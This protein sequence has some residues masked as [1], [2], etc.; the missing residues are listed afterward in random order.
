MAGLSELD[1]TNFNRLPNKR[2]LDTGGSAAFSSIFLA[3][4]FFCSH[5]CLRQGA[6]KQNPRPPQRDEFPQGSNASPLGGLHQ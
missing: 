5:L 6:G 4:S 1:H 3:S 2:T